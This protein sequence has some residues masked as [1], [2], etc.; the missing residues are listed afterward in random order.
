MPICPPKTDEQRDRWENQ[1]GKALKDWVTRIMAHDGI[2]R[3]HARELVLHRITL[4]DT[5]ADI[6]FL[7]QPPRLPGPRSL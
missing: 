4:L 2:S 6:E 1:V 3:A 5:S 7:E